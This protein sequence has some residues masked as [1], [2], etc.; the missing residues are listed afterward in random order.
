MILYKSLGAGLLAL[1]IGQRLEGVILLT[2]D[3]FL[4]SLLLLKYL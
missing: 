3:I 1:F 4:S 2:A